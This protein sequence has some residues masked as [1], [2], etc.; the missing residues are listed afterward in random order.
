MSDVKYDSQG[1]P[2]VETGLGIRYV[3]NEGG[4]HQTPRGMT[5]ADY[6]E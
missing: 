1:R 6:V 5:Q 4:L 2:Y 3:D